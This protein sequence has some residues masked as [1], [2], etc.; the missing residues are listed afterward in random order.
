MEKGSIAEYTKQWELDHSLQVMKRTVE[1]WCKCPS[2]ALMEDRLLHLLYAV[3]PAMVDGWDM[4]AALVM[5]CKE[6]H[7]RWKENHGNGGI[8]PVQ[9]GAVV[10]Q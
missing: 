2:G 4:P 7:A 8:W 6:C 3:E 1:F 10:P 5:R 9:R